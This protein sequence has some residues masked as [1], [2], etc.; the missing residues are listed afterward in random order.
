VTAKE[1]LEIDRKIA[2][3]EAQSK[4]HVAAILSAIDGAAPDAIREAAGVAQC[5][6]QKVSEKVNVLRN[7]SEKAAAR[8]S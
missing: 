7:G 2:T 8:A 3:K 4:A 6:L 5:A 1:V